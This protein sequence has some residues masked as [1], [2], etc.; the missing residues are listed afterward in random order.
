M[1]GG[2]PEQGPAAR[3]WWCRRRTRSRRRRRTGWTLGNARYVHAVRGDRVCVCAC[4]SHTHSESFSLSLSPSLSV[5]LSLSLSPAAVAHPLTMHRLAHTRP[6]P[7]PTSLQHSCNVQACRAS[8]GSPSQESRGH[9]K[10][11]SPPFPPSTHKS[12]RLPR[13]HAHIQAHTYAYAY[14]ARGHAKGASPPP[15]IHTQML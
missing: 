11:A 5:S 15:H 12:T 9:A 3:R 1:S 10:G 6:H 8:S 7:H 2:V 14:G 4:V 13:A